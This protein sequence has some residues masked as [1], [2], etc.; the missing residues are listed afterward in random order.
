MGRMVRR[1]ALTIPME[2]ST[3]AQMMGSTSAPG[4]RDGMVSGEVMSEC[5]RLWQGL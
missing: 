4:G 1:L 2:F 3:T 5:V